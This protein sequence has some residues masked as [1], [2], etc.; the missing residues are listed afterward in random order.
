MKKYLDRDDEG[1][2]DGNN[3]RNNNDNAT[4]RSSSDG[5]VFD[6]ITTPR[7]RLGLAEEK[8]A[9][10]VMVLRQRRTIYIRIVL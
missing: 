10:T 9:T 8:Q 3:D 4:D 6:T 2:N 5:P 7:S 1:D